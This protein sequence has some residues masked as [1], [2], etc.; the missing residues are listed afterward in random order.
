MKQVPTSWHPNA[1]NHSTTVLLTKACKEPVLWIGGA[2]AME[3]DDAVVIQMQLHGIQASLPWAFHANMSRSNCKAERVQYDTEGMR[4]VN[5]HD[6]KNLL[7]LYNLILRAEAMLLTSPG[8]P[9]LQN[10]SKFLNTRSFSVRISL[11]DWFSLNR[12][13]F[14]FPRKPLGMTLLWS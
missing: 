11:P 5:L 6:Q 2:T 3:R 1:S 12:L 14:R 13:L 4:S 7:N 10:P 8:V 9:Y